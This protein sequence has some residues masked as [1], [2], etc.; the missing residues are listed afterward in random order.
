MGKHFI[1]VGRT[2]HAIAQGIVDEFG[3]A[4]RNDR[5]EPLIDRPGPVIQGRFSTYED[6]ESSAEIFVNANVA[7]HPIEQ[8]LTDEQKAQIAAD[9]RGSDVTIVHSVSGHNTSS[10][11]MSLL[12]MTTHLK[13]TMGVSRIRLIAPHLP[14][15]RNDRAFRKAVIGPD[16]K[17]TLSY[18]YNAVSASIYAK[19]L[20]DAY[21]DKVVGFEPHSRDAQNHY[22]T[23]LGEGNVRFIRMGDFF[24]EKIGSEYEVVVD[25]LSRIAGGSPD[26]WDKPDDYGIARAKSFLEKLYANTEFDDLK[27]IEDLA[28][29]IY[30]YG[31]VKERISPSKTIIKEFHGDVRGKI[32]IIIDDII[33]GGSTMMQAAERLK[34]EGAFMVIAVATHAVLTE[35]ALPKLLNNPHIDKVMVTDTI[36]R[37]IEKLNAVSPENQSKLIIGTISPLVNR[38]IAR[39]WD[40]PT[41]PAR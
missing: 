29:R 4:G 3:H 24:A 17:Q 9:L 30:M 6:G 12:H 1:M 27:Y 14:Y 20:R 36:P 28:Q 16:G 15:L 38:E 10:R 26:G 13:E 23:R 2:S 32:C 19:Q 41:P 39:S 21:V 18:Q 31:I 7:D 25:G 5:G 34:K 40:E 11:A 22:R 35:G 37:V 33:S 8:R